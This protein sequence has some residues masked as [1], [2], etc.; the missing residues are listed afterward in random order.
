MSREWMVTA[1]LTE[2]VHMW[3]RFG[4]PQPLLDQNTK[5]KNHN[6]LDALGEGLRM[7]GG[8][9]TEFQTIQLMIAVLIQLGFIPVFS[10]INGLTVEL[11][12]LMVVGGVILVPLFGVM[13]LFPFKWGILSERQLEKLSD[14]LI[15]LLACQVTSIIV[16]S[17]MIPLTFYSIIPAIVLLFVFSAEIHL[18]LEVGLVDKMCE[19]G[20]SRRY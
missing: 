18:I 19:R 7:F 14:R 20:C 10:Y 11:F 15:M 2:L 12:P 3:K 16:S 17:V 5:M 6:D 9:L 4:R 1:H 8:W 13:T